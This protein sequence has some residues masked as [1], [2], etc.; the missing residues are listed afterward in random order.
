VAAAAPSSGL[1]PYL[2]GRQ[3]TG[4]DR[5]AEAAAQ[6]ARA[7]ALG[8][9]DPGFTIE[10]RRLQ[11]ISSYRAGDLAGARAIFAELQ[12]SSDPLARAEARDWIARCDFSEPAR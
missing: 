11:A 5:F 6:L 1:G 8:L 7:L 3:L 2:V 10:A 9:P 12:R 4:H